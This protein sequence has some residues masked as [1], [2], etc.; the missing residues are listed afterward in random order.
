MDAQWLV[1]TETYYHNFVK[2]IF[3]SVIS[4]LQLDSGRTF[5]QAE[6]YYF[7]RWYFEQDEKT[8]QIVKNLVA[9]GQIEFA[10][11]GWVAHD[12]ACPSYN[13]IIS[14]IY[15]GHRFLNDE[16]GV[17]PKIG[18]QLDSYGSSAGNALLY[19]QMGYEGMVIGRLNEDILENHISK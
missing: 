14:S 18:W 17:I 11:G 13:A 9:E 2:K 19:S 3:D 16:F 10:N 4:S 15:E 8:R 1:P 12:E 5:T 7:Q 6:I